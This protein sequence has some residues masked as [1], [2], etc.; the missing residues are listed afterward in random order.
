MPLYNAKHKKT[1][2]VQEVFCG[3]NDKD[4]WLV[5]NPKWEFMVSAPNIVDA[6]RLSNTNERRKA[7]GFRDVL[8]RVKTKNPGSK[9]DTDV[10]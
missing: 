9:I 5:D 2:E 8:E 10:F 4:Q 1:G 3:M 6:A 7:T